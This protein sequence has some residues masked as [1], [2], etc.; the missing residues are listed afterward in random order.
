MSQRLD[1]IILRSG[2]IQ[3]RQVSGA[4]DEVRQL[5]RYDVP[6]LIQQ[7]RYF[8]QLVSALRQ[9]CRCD[10]LGSGEE[11][12]NGGCQLREL[13]RTARE[14]LQLIADSQAG[15]P[16]S[17]TGDPCIILAQIDQALD[18]NI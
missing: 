13:L 15:R 8:E 14:W 3:R 1:E 6:W 11:Y 9:P 17:Y 16:V 4:L 12:C 18:E 2:R 10:P 7:H 5:V